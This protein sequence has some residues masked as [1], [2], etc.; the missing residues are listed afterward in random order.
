M[1]PLHTYLA[2]RAANERRAIAKAIRRH[3]HLSSRPIV[4][5]GYHL[6]GDVGAPLALLWGTNENAAPNLV[7]V[8]EPRNRQLRFDALQI[9]GRAL[10]EYLSMFALTEVE[11]GSDGR[12]ELLCVDAPQIVVPNRATAD[13]LFGIVGRFTRHLSA[14]GSPPAP[15][16]V[17]FAGKHLSF[18]HNPLPGS[19][20]V[21]PAAET[22]SAHWQTGQL[23]SE[24]L[25]L[26]AL[27]GWIDPGPSM[28]GQSAAHDG[29]RLPPAGPLSDPNWDADDLAPLI[30]QW[31]AAGGTNAARLILHGE[32]ENLMLEQMNHTWEDCWHALRLLGGLPEG[33]RVSRRW[34]RDRKSW[35]RH[36]FAMDGGTAHFR[37]IPT[38]VQ[39]AKTLAVVEKAT[40]ELQAEMALDDPLVMASYVASGEAL[41]AKVTSVDATR[42]IPGAR[43]AVCRP[44]VTLEALLPF[45]RPVGA[46]LF[47]A[48]APDVEFEILSISG[49]VVVAQVNK[50]ALSPKTIAR[51]PSL[52]DAVVLSPFGSS[53]FYPRPDLDEVP[54]T[55]YLPEPIE[56]L[57]Q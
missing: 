5:V 3:V 57:P 4:I 28:D 2:L 34:E 49:N 27:L 12:A 54:W 33:E 10:T 1:N 21:I 44:L 7:V 48:S 55:H 16:E 36:H 15:P 23:P 45:S 6:A 20:L 38:P 41:S 35:S 52:G 19:S 17:P 40:T 53:E 26:S 37:N 56:E 47:L 30:S 9:F 22:L 51:L 24:D 18:F 13:W 39:S 50:G 11:S 32:F 29:E 8:P 43:R 42:R 25:N 46:T 14:T 31:H